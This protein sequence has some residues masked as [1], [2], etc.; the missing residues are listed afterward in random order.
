M[1]MFCQALRSMIARTQRSWF[2]FH[3]RHVGYM[4]LHLQFLCEFFH[5]Y[6]IVMGGYSHEFYQMCEALII[7]EL[8]LNWSRPKG[9]IQ[10]RRTQNYVTLINT[11]WDT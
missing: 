3:P 7:I 9:Q 10:D 1:T 5:V 4:S 2:E 11:S 8:I 6:I